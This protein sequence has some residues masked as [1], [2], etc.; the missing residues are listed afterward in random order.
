MNNAP[1]KRLGTYTVPMLK[2][3]TLLAVPMV[4]LTLL[5]G[6]IVLAQQNGPSD[7]TTTAPQATP[8]GDDPT[9]T[10]T[11]TPTATVTPNMNRTPNEQPPVLPNVTPTPTVVA[12]TPTPLPQVQQQ[13]QPVPTGAAYLAAN[14]PAN[15]RA[16]PEAILPPSSPAATSA[17][18]MTMGD[19][20]LKAVPEGP[21]FP[22]LFFVPMVG[23][24]V[25]RATELPQPPS[26]PTALNAP[27][28]NL[29]PVPER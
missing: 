24:D 1:R 11:R 8:Q 15:L 26:A 29:L 19:G 2:R 17:A 5:G 23:D 18:A 4:A 28:Q 3:L 10:P 27:V 16:V 22:S 9:A 12:A 25:K 21:A 7:L 14:V 13:Q 6:S 20:V